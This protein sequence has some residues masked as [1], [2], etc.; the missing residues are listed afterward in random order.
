M[1]K[2]DRSR[3]KPLFQ[4]IAEEMERKIVY[5]EY[6]PGS[7]LPSERSLAEQ[8]DVNRSTVVQAYEELRAAGLIER[9]KGSGTKVCQ[10]NPGIQTATP[11]WRKY[12]DSGTFMPNLP[13]IRRIRSELR[14][15][16]P[17]IDFA[18]GELSP[19][20]FPQD[21]VQQLLK[22]RTFSAVLGYDDPHGYLPL[23][24][25]LVTLLQNEL[26]IRT[27]ESSILITSGSQ[28]SLYLITQCLLRPGDAIAIEDP[29]Y[30]YSLPMFQS[31]GLRIFPLPA[32]ADTG[33]D[34]EHI[35]A[36]H[37]QHRLRMIFL[38]PTFQ[39]P[40]GHV[41][42]QDK[43]ARL[44]QVTAELGIPIVEDDPFSL[45]AFD[46][47]P[48][49]SLKSLDTNGQVLYIGSLS[50]IAASGFRI[51]WLIAPH[52]V[53]TR[54]ADARQQMDFGLSVI[55]QWAASEFISSGH[56]QRHVKFLQ[57]AL[58]EKMHRLT[59]A[60]REHLPSELSFTSPVGGL[61][62]WCR[63]NKKLDSDKLLEEAVRRGVIYV[64]GSVFGSDPDFI[65]LSFA[66]PDTQHIERGIKLLAEAV[67]SL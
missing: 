53:V 45:T 38:N 26:H 39:N 32:H 10:P 30:C 28:Q 23:R 55:P 15:E 44:L 34:P 22:E 12:L 25:T 52:S 1:W 17:I 29:S 13:L 50:K 66:R 67:H 62:L 21:S 59:M 31:A 33:I 3:K 11:N 27:T 58:F 2:P 16:L 35:A 61:N 6:P 54:L 8:L 57:L 19:D 40:T 5:G 20:L 51:G 48:P 9:R 60:L 42:T 46:G 7:V 41:M 47:I 65:R 37:R 24:Q 56:F 4:Q 18:S 43:Q 64:P 63:W 14:K 36:L 49:R